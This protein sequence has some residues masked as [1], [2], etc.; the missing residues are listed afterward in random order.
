MGPNGGRYDYALTFELAKLFSEQQGLKPEYVSVYAGS[1]EP[2]HYTVL[3]FTSPDPG[4]CD[5]RPRIRGRH[6]GR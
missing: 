3:A 1:S 6:A 4:L 2:L 5:R